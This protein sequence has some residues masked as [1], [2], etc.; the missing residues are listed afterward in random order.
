[1][2]KGLKGLVPTIWSTLLLCPLS[3]FSPAFPSTFFSVLP[4]CFDLRESFLAVYCN[5]LLTFILI[6]FLISPTQCKKG[7]R[8]VGEVDIWQQ[9][10][11]TLYVLLKVVKD[12][13][14]LTGLTKWKPGKSGSHL[15]TGNQTNYLGIY[16]YSYILKNPPSLTII[17]IRFEY[18][19]HIS[20]YGLPCDC[21]VLAH[22]FNCYPH[23]HLCQLVSP[24]RVHIFY[25]HSSTFCNFGPGLL[26][27]TAFLLSSRR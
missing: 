15:R 24:T 18:L 25:S 27:P 12:E 8:K 13:E 5:M 6:V 10:I 22:S 2:S 16:S 11:Y 1:M 4:L 7:W 17:T 9:N 3:F 14:N 26:I 19:F 23:S 20:A 21:P